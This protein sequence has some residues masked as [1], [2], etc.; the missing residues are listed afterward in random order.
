MARAPF[1]VAVLPFRHAI[2]GATEF[3]VFRRSDAGYWQAIA[4]GGED[5]E[6]AAQAAQ[7]EAH[8]EARIPLTSPLAE[9]TTTASVPVTHF[10]DREHW[11][12]D[13]YV[14]RTHYFG[15]DTTDVDIAI[16]KEHV[17]FRW[18]KFDE[19]HQSLHWRS[20]AVALWE[21]AQRIQNGQL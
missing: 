14:I 11:P 3:A 1:Q 4:G 10:G 5:N 6:T 2:P 18:A 16:S 13:L 12:R 19:A 15:V 8:E 17:E 7:R 9:L 20:D 21:L